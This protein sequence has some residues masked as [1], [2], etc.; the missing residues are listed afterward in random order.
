MNIRM[1]DASI[2]FHSR[3]SPNENQELVMLAQQRRQLTPRLLE[4]QAKAQALAI[5]LAH[6]DARILELRQR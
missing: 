1:V 3:R 5:R 4:A 2:R 6:I